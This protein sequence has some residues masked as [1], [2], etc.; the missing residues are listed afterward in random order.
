M[1]QKILHFTPLEKKNHDGKKSSVNPVKLDNRSSFFDSLTGFIKYNNATVIILAVIL[2]LGGGA[3]AAGPEAIG[4]KQTSVQGVDNTALLAADPENFNM[5][6]KIENIEQDGEYYYV[7]YSYLDLVMLDNAWQYQLNSKTQKVSQKIK[8]DIGE[9]MAKFLAKH[10]EARTRELKQEKSQAEAQGLEKREQVTEY[11][12]LI[13]KTLDVVAAVFPGYEPVVKVEMPSPPPLDLPLSKGENTERVPAADDLTKIYNDYLAAHDQDKDGVLDA[14][15]NCP[16]VA[17]AD[18]KDSDN[19]GIGDAC[20]LTLPLPTGQAGSPAP[21]VVAGEGSATT[22]SNE[23]TT[24]QTASSTDQT[25]GSTSSSS[26]PQN[27]EVIEPPTNS[28]SAPADSPANPAPDQP[29][30][31]PTVPAE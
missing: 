8:Q 10:H 23:M 24:N 31:T 13:G 28:G 18:Q 9:Y 15:D 29:A 17:N 20:S 1:L 7:T 16:T 4:Q 12:G 27:V 14:G 19:D 26:E 21:G 3:L 6:F 25:T 22:T 30:E 11:S 2:I 5:D